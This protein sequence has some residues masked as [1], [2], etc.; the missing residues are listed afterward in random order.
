MNK[1]ELEE[2]KNLLFQRREQL[3]KNIAEYKMEIGELK[4]SEA[5]DEADLATISSDTAVEEAISKQLQKELDEI[6]YALKKIEEGTYGICEMCEEE[7]GVERLKVKPQARYC[8]VCREIVE[9]TS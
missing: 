8:I 2:F 3:L 9:K 4:N 7:I 5:S 1:N 6:D